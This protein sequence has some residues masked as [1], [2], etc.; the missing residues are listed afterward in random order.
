M[1]V[2]VWGQFDGFDARRGSLY[3]INL[4]LRILCTFPF[5]YF[6][7]FPLSSLLSCSHGKQLWDSACGKVLHGQRH[8]NHGFFLTHQ[9]YTFRIWSST[10]AKCGV[11]R[12]VW[13]TMAAT[14]RGNKLALNFSLVYDLRERRAEWE[15]PP[16][17]RTAFDSD[18]YWSI[19]L[20]SR[21]GLST[22]PRHCG[23]F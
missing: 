19:L 11:G 8:M 5:F 13:M 1:A 18:R 12:I 2:S 15:G 20:S 16:L 7:F 4:A 17:G 22:R 3:A 14:L 9:R 23:P 10:S 6:P 21:E